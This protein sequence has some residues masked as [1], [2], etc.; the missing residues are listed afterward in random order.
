MDSHFQDRG[1]PRRD[2]PS[3]AQEVTSLPTSSFWVCSLHTS[4]TGNSSFLH[5]AEKE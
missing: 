4:N 1:E 5:L 3:K 2:S